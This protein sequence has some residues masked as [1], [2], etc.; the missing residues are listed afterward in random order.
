M[1]NAIDHGIKALLY[2]TSPMINQSQRLLKTLSAHMMYHGSVTLN[3]SSSS[4]SSRLRE[5]GIGSAVSEALASARS[6]LFASSPLFVVVVASSDE[7]DFLLYSSSPHS[8]FSTTWMRLRR[9]LRALTFCAASAST[10]AG[11][12]DWYVCK[13]VFGQCVLLANQKGSLPKG[14]EREGKATRTIIA[15][16]TLFMMLAR[17]AD[18]MIRPTMYP[19]ACLETC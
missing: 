12:I 1:V 3:D 13:C 9:M 19:P 16:A 15:I 11:C 18:I 5:L 7:E 10:T 8:P 2:T 4:A 6:W 17:R 14:K